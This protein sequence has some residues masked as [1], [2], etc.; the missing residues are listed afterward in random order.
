MSS[1]RITI[2]RLNP[3]WMAGRDCPALDE[4]CARAIDAGFHHAFAR[5]L[6]V[7][8][9]LPAKEKAVEGNLRSAEIPA[10]YSSA[11]RLPNESIPVR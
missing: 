9:I 11:G 2:N 4:M 3:T 10:A 1:L 6:R 8:Q 5:R 7:F